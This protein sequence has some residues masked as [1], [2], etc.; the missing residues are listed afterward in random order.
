MCEPISP[1]PP[2]S[3]NLFPLSSMSVAMIGRAAWVAK[4]AA[5]A[6]P[7]QTATDARNAAFWDELCGS[8]LARQV[9]IEDASAESLERFDA[10][11]MASYPYLGRTS[12]GASTAP[13]CSRS[14]S[15]T[16]RSALC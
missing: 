13:S 7:G 15:D 11:Y 2:I 16:A 6:A 3:T 8:A 12:R 14:G 9:G 1:A 4:V 5:M 10:A